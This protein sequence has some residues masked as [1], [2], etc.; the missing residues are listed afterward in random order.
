MNL[1]CA[2]GLPG[3]EVI[4]V[5]GCLKIL[6]NWAVGV[7]TVTEHRLKTEFHSNPQ[8]YDYSEP[9]FRMVKLVMTLKDHCRVGYN[10][11]KTEVKLTDPMELHEQFIRNRPANSRSCVMV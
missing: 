3:A 5:P 9:L 7:R 4:D 6:D 8:K 1:A 10:P 2:V 11:A